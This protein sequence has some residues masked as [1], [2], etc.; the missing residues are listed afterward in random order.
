MMKKTLIPSRFLSHEDENEADRLFDLSNGCEKFWSPKIAGTDFTNRL[1]ACKTPLG[2]PIDWPQNRSNG[3]NQ[4]KRSF[5]NYDHKIQLLA[6]KKLALVFTSPQAL[7]ESVPDHSRWDRAYIRSA[8][9][10]WSDQMKWPRFFL[11]HFYSTK[12]PQLP[13]STKYQVYPC[14]A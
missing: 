13:S 8:A 14:T 12:W 1:P 2:L 3:N 9:S 7:V 11:K 6:V 5:K 4:R 10:F